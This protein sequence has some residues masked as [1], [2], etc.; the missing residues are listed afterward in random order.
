MEFHN[1]NYNIT[2]DYKTTLQ[3]TTKTTTL[4]KTTLQNEKTTRQQHFKRLQ[5]N[6]T[7][8]RLQ[9]NTTKDYNSKTTPQK[10]TIV[11]QHNKILQY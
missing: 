2:K 4:Q 7:K 9:D 11:R 1:K 5:D 6:T 8:E 10:T 3:K